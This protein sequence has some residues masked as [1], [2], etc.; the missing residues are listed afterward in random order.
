[1]DYNE[2]VN[3]ALNRM[4]SRWCEWQN[5]LKLGDD[6]SV[7]R[8]SVLTRSFSLLHTC[9][10]S[11]PSYQIT[12]KTFLERIKQVANEWILYLC[13]ERLYTQAEDVIAAMVGSSFYV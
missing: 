3:E 7:I 8:E 12:T 2:S 1:M 13:T 5:N 10:L 4:D 11:H 9:Y 6:V